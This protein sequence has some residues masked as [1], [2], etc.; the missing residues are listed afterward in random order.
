MLKA[1]ADWL[2]NMTAGA[3]GALM[4]GVIGLEAGVR[5][6]RLV[7]SHLERAI[8]L[9]PVSIRETLGAEWRIAFKEEPPIG[10]FSFARKCFRE[11]Q[12]LARVEEG[13]GK[14]ADAEI[15]R[16]AEVALDLG[17]F[18]SKPKHI[19]RLPW[20]PRSPVRGFA[21]FALAALCLALA[22]VSYL[23]RAAGAAERAKMEL[24]KLQIEKLKI[25][26]R[27]LKTEEAVRSNYSFIESWA[28]QLG[29]GPAT[30]GQICPNYRCASIEPVIDANQQL[31]VRIRRGNLRAL[32][33][34][35]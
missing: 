17:V 22:P 1:I 24:R 33:G 6:H 16:E 25:E 29:M 35:S 32:P 8:N 31:P 20:R 19:L 21:G 23:A 13:A 12:R 18:R 11:A 10:R 15:D 26:I 2:S 4:V 3:V 7:S 34:G 5:Y 14:A 30:F 27:R 9:L 28:E